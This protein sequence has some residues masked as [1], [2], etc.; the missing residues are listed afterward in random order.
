[1]AK[2]KIP[3]INMAK[4]T[5]DVVPYFFNSSIGCNVYT[6]ILAADTSPQNKASTL[7]LETSSP[8][9]MTIQ[10][11]PT[12]ANIIQKNSGTD[13]FLKYLKNK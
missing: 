1:M 2:D 6:Q 4:P 9:C 10:S 12:K 13:G 3:Q 7:K 11:V 8:S 5:M